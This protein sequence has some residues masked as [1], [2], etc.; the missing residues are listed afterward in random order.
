MGIFT[1][2]AIKYSCH[3]CHS[4]H[5]L[6]YTSLYQS[7]LE[8]VDSYQCDKCGE[9]VLPT[10]YFRFRGIGIFIKEHSILGWALVTIPMLLVITLGFIVSLLLLGEFAEFVNHWGESV[11]GQGNILP[12]WLKLIALL[13]FI[14]FIY[15]S[16]NF[17]AKV[18]ATEK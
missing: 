15:Y 8:S 2:K 9:D 3:H 13:S 16:I 11:F 14:Y 17:I 18:K 5:L 7:L 4:K 1:Q 6:I 12:E 10:L